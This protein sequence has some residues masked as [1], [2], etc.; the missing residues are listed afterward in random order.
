MRF[1][2]R[3]HGSTTCRTGVLNSVAA[4]R[5]AN[6]TFWSGLNGGVLTNFVTKF[7]YL[8]Q[9]STLRS[10]RKSL[11][12]DP[13]HGGLGIGWL[14]EAPPTATD[15]VYGSTFRTEITW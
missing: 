9:N 10:T 8:R 12:L 2:S 3:Q 5:A 14:G 6:G 1:T 11:R 13:V 4:W 15:K 7:N